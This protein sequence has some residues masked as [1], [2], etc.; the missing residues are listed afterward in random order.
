MAFAVT[1]AGVSAGAF[2]IA[3]EGNIGVGKSTLCRNIVSSSRSRFP[4]DVSDIVLLERAPESFLA[5]FY[6][7]PKQ[8]GFAFQLFMT[9]MRRLQ[10]SACNHLRVDSEAARLFPGVVSQLRRSKG[11]A[12]SGFID[13]SGKVMEDDQATESA[14]S[15]EAHAAESSPCALTWWDRSAIGDMFF[16]VANLILGRILP[17][18]FVTYV[19]IVCD[20]QTGHMNGDEVNADTLIERLLELYPMD[21]IVYL[22]DSP[23]ACKFRVHSLRQN[24]S[25]SV[26]ELEYLALIDALHW[27]LLVERLS[28]R[29]LCRVLVFPWEAYSN[30]PDEIRDVVA[31]YCS[32]SACS[33][34]GPWN[35]APMNFCHLDQ[36][37]ETGNPDELVIRSREQLREAVISRTHRPIK[38]LIILSSVMWIQTETEADEL[39]GQGVLQAARRVLPSFQLSLD[40]CK[41]FIVS[42]ALQGCQHVI[43]AEIINPLSQTTPKAG[44]TA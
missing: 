14:G 25:E 23:V 44:N 40:E 26:I 18:E 28:R 36:V 24:E 1:A 8:Y 41:S 29:E 43:V 33:T 12:S 19:N 38:T 34:S 39:L 17:S 15:L 42:Y 6:S 16:C 5:L 32:K 31:S 37:C 4:G 7:N 9:S 30:R 22:W 11:L 13:M 2:A 21:A 3:L 35:I 27:H 10:G 20:G